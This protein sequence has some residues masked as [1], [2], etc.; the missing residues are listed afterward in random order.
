MK[1][2]D[3]LKI[4]SLLAIVLS[5]LHI[6]DDIVRGF[7][8]GGFK[9]ASGIAIMVVWLYGTLVLADRLPGKII[10]L[11]GSVLGSGIP[12]VHMRGLGLVGGRIANS[13]GKLFFVWTLLMLGVVSVFC[14]IL[15]VQALWSRRR[16]PVAE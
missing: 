14:L 10:I 16:K 11:L 9:N 5:T 15:S 1:Q 12:L 8:P 6:S 7:E 2:N 3:L 13:N 4:M